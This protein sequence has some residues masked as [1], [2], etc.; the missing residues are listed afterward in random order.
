VVDAVSEV[1][2]V[3]S[4]AIHPAPDLSAEQMRL[5]GRVVNLDS[6][7]ILLIEPGQLLTTSEASAM[8]TLAGAGPTPS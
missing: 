3:P 6:R 8:A 5:V 2:K 4:E 1:L 7:M